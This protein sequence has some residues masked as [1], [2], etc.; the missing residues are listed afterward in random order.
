MLNKSRRW[1]IWILMMIAYST[2]AASEEPP[3]LPEVVTN[4]SFEKADLVLSLQQLAAKAGFNLV[5]TPDVKGE[6]S[7]QLTNVSY[8]QAFKII[9]QSYGYQ[10]ESEG[11]YLFIGKPGQVITNQNNITF[12]QIHYTDTKLL[13][14]ML[15]KLLGVGDQ[16]I[17]DD[18]SRMIV[19]K[20]SKSLI[21]QV[22]RV[23]TTLDRKM[24]QITIEVKVIAVS[25]TAVRKMGMELQVDKSSLSWNETSSGASIIVNLIK[26]GVTWNTIFKNLISNGKARLISSPSV[27]TMNG[28]EA[29][30]IIADKIP[31]E[32]SDEDGN[33][34]VDFVDVGIKLV[35]T[36]IVQNGNELVIDLNTQVSSLGDKMGSSYRIINKEVKSRIQASIGETVFLGGLISQEERESVAKIPKL[37]DIPVLGK[38]FQNTERSNTENELII[39]MTPSWN[40]TSFIFLDNSRN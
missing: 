6:I 17:S 16:I 25:T 24:P 27:S 19:V 21:E 18:R 11:N 30:I 15:K 2:C 38:I 9:V 36:P 10:C 28:Q 35:F 37:G 1:I 4:I 26:K 33:I 14:E 5:I 31:I 20:G 22:E 3:P 29:S 12:F 39:T 8:I 40:N 32:R 13:A 34:S 23:I 7:I